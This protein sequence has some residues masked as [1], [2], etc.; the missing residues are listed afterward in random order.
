MPRKRRKKRS[1][2]QQII[3]NMGLFWKRGKVR[4]IGSRRENKEL[5]GIRANE[6][7][8]GKVD[9]WKQTGIYSLYDADYHLIYVGQAGFGDKSC[10][11]S[12]LKHHCRDNLAGRWDMFSWFGLRK[13]TNKNILGN[14][15]QR[16]TDALSAIGNVLEAILIEVAEPP[17]NGQ[18]GRFGKKVERYLQVDESIDKYAKVHEKILSEI[19]KLSDKL[20]K[21]AR[22]TK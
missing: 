19:A 6:K 2:G 18:G 16:K 12:R 4:W 17:M 20:K 11:G 13:V 10:I 3:A 5:V 14:K 21:K 1:T 9:F 22:K 8:A 7:K 15:P